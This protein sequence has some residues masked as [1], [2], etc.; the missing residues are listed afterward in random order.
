MNAG[1]AIPLRVVALLLSVP[2]ARAEIAV[3]LAPDA[4]TRF[5]HEPFA[6]RL[7]VESDA[8][9]ETPDLPA[10]PGLSV[11][12]MR[13]MPPDPARRKHAF[14]IALIAERDG[15]LTLPPFAVRAG[16]ESASTSPLRL[17]VRAPRPAAE[18]GLEVTVEPT[19]LR[20]GQPATV[21]VTWTSAVP[22]ARCKQLLFKIP[23][24]ADARCRIFPLDPP[25]PGGGRIGLPV[26]NQRVVARKGIA[27]DGRRFLAFSYRLVPG[28][29]CVLRAHR[30]RLACALLEG[31]APTDEPPEHFYNQFFVAPDEGESHERVYLTAPVPEIAV[32]ALGEAGRRADFADIVGPCELRA[33]VAP[34]NLVVGQPALFTVHLEGMDFARHITGLPAA[35]FDSLRPEFRI[36]AEPIRETITDSTR[37]FTHALRPLR[38]GIARIP[39]IVIQK[40]NPLAG[41][42]Q[43]M[44]S[45]PI[46]VVVKP[47]PGLGA[48]AVAPR[49]DSEPP[50]PLDGVRQNRPGAQTMMAILSLLEFLGRHWWAI[51]PLPPLLWLALRP[52]ARRWERC[53]RDPVYA[54]ATGAWRRFRQAARS[55][56]EVA[57]RHYLADR[58]GLCAEALTAETAAEA[59]RARR[60]EPG[61][62][63]ETR[64]RFEERDAAEYG[65]RPAP[66]SRSIRDL[67][68]R[69]QR[70]TLPLLFLATGLLAPAP[71]RAAAEETPDALF[72]RAIE[73]RGERPDEAQALFVEAALRFESAGRLLNAG[74]SWF[75]AGES[76]RAL[77]SYRAAERRWP[78]DRQL[79][80]SIAFLRAN[81]ADAFPAPAT[82]PGR[83]ASFW[84]QFCSG[85]AVLR[86]GLF[87][88]AY[89]IAWTFFLGAQLAGWRIRRTIWAALGAAVL[90]PL[91]SL[92][93]SGF[94]PAEGVVVQNSVARLGPGYAYDPAFQQ[95]LHEAT[96]FSWLE[97]RQGWVRARLPDASEGWLRESDCMK[98]E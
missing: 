83:A 10:V 58:L 71:G 20:V 77:V 82:A 79:R 69:L 30:A 68:R 22:F 50:I 74:N 8:P 17:R 80:E 88:V 52:L 43:T 53:R 48:Q 61:L 2:T 3:H 51:V 47:D 78:F 93:Q 67:V 23:I 24:L 7:E 62:I 26:N 86:A 60:V 33:S 63:E 44:R 90:V 95:P 38:P 59:L 13:R 65:K 87:V 45:A 18:M 39:A 36:S 57:W 15:V 85:S 16:G 42:Y 11:V 54:R 64:R 73:M 28:E 66:S 40:F 70:A 25:G 55:D 4:A 46:P 49:L 34:T 97:T 72:A 27:P 32:R 35:A 5:I 9:P 94:R 6:L 76:G 31:E 1:R 89:L 37:S 81:R 19:A 84:L 29:A 98:V 75:F 56:E 96:E 92:V 91:L 12:S 14:Q 21:T 41:E